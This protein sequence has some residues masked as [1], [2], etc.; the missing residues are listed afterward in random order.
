MVLVSGLESG[1][2]G[3]FDSFRRTMLDSLSAVEVYHFAYTGYKRTR[4]NCSVTLF[5]TGL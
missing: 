5:T 1:I 4:Y 3:D 2:D